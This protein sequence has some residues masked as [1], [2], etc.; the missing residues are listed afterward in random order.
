MP[1]HE[2]VRLENRLTAYLNGLAYE[3]LRYFIRNHPSHPLEKE[4][5]TRNAF[6]SK[7]LVSVY[8]GQ[9][10]RLQA[11]DYLYENA[12]PEILFQDGLY[13]YAKW[14]GMGIDRAIFN[15]CQIV[16]RLV[17]RV[18]SVQLGLTENCS[19]DFCVDELLIRNFFRQLKVKKAD[20]KPKKTCRR[21]R[22]RKLAVSA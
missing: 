16:N 12:D 18:P 9:E 22:R 2:T 15:Y 1:T 14:K 5:F 3:R 19:L 10:P 4:L 7:V 17:A 8:Y 6:Y 21:K 13:L 20:S 11:F